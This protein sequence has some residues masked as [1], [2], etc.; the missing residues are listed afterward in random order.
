MPSR[1][2]QLMAQNNR[3]ETPSDMLAEVHIYVVPHDKWIPYRRLAKNRVVEETVS[4][5]F[6]RVLPET[7]LTELRTA[8]REQLPEEEL[9]HHFV[10]IKSVGR[11]FTQVKPYQEGVVKVKNFLPPKAPEPEIHI[12]EISEEL[13]RNASSL[14]SL[15]LS[16]ELSDSQFTDTWTR[17]PSQADAPLTEEEEDLWGAQGRSAAEAAFTEARIQGTRT[18]A[19]D[20]DDSG[21]SDVRQSS[22]WQGSSRRG[23]A[24]RDRAKGKTRT[25]RNA[26]AKTGHNSEAESEKGGESGGLEADDETSDLNSRRGS[27]AYG[28]EHNNSEVEN[29]LGDDKENLDTGYHED[30][31]SSSPHTLSYREASGDVPS[32]VVVQGDQEGAEEATNLL[33]ENDS[34]Q[35]ENERSFSELDGLR[36]SAEELVKASVRKA[37]AFVI[38]SDMPDAAADGNNSQS[39]NDGGAE[40]QASEGTGSRFDQ[41]GRKNRIPLRRSRSEP[42]RRLGPPKSQAT[43]AR[44]RGKLATSSSTA[45]LVG[46]TGRQAPGGPRSDIAQR[47]PN[48]RGER[49]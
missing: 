23:S 45:R 26:D 15:V 25:K 17:R 22:S 20:D 2:E 47:V 30:F 42:P 3:T 33:E 36:L 43:K 13:L 8:L 29:E 35:Q 11:N 12:L 10:F 39:E 24:R 1:V 48:A 44:G 9:L 14:G 21:N 41:L 6:V 5:G 46:R 18:R 7:T 4:V 31:S 19:S 49:T 28:E 34:F 27:V 40:A 16:D 38:S 32:E 37:E